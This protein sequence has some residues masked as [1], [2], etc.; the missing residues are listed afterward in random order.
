MIKKNN[1]LLTLLLILLTSY[2]F[3]Q[4]RPT[5]VKKNTNSNAKELFHDLNESGDSLILKSDYRIYRVEIMRSDFSK[6]Y[7]AF[8]KSVK[9]PLYDLP[10]GRFSVLV[11]TNRKLILFNLFKDDIIERPNEITPLNIKE[12]INE[13]N[14]LP[15][16]ADIKTKELSFSGNL[17]LNGKADA[18]RSN[19]NE[20][21]GYWAVV[22]VDNNFGSHKV[23]RIINERSKDI[24]I[25]KNKHDIK[26]ITGR[27]N[28]LIIWEVYDISS[29]MRFKFNSGNL[30]NSRESK[31]FN[32]TPIYMTK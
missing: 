22:S 15:R 14:S 31:F 23:S 20:V 27:N 18:I 19:S 5:R 21:E 8:E 25:E 9:I 11:S 29:F 28:K 3:S 26:S 12:N 10:R 6:H 32:N 24:L 2:T 1:H 30:L 4:N 17:S 7:E 13:I 16:I